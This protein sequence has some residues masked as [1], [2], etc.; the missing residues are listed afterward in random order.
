MIPTPAARDP[1]PRQGAGTHRA[2]AP[3][4]APNPPQ[5]IYEKEPDA[6]KATPELYAHHLF[7]AHPY[8]HTLLACD[9]GGAPIGLAM[10]FFNFSTWTGRPGLYL[11]DL[12]V[13]EAHRGAG[14]GK[15]LF[16]RLAAVAQE[17]VRVL[18]TGRE[19]DADGCMQ[20]CARMDWSVLKV[21]GIVWWAVGATDGA[22]SG[23]SRRSTFTKSG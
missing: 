16:A 12:F 19:R 14:V 20:G 2:L 3:I 18:C 11:E 1:R 22:R 21:R 6:A 13:R 7:G 17:R 8:A 5:A 23:T 9:A 4:R 15:A 10:Y